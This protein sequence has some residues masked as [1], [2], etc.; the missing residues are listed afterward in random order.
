VNGRRTKAGA[1]QSD[2]PQDEFK[3]IPDLLDE[4]REYAGHYFSAR[5]DLAR[6]KAR[7]TTAKFIAMGLIFLA[8]GGAVLVSVWLF[9]T[10]IALGLSELFGDRIWL[11]F[12][13]AGLLILGLM[14]AMTWYGLSRWKKSSRDSTIRQYEQRHKSQHARFGRSVAQSCPDE[15]S[16]ETM[17]ESGI[18]VDPSQKDDSELEE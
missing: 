12:L 15:Q 6:A 5:R 3:R 17:C 4:L 1:P 11:G 10:G 14:S 13:S 16:R 8:G 9:G 18:Y 2:R 7:Q